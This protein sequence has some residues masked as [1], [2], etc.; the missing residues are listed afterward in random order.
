MQKCGFKW[1]CT[2]CRPKITTLNSGDET[3]CGSYKKTEAL[4]NSM[5]MEMNNIKLKMEEI[6]EKINT[7]F[8]SLKQSLDSPKSTSWADIVGEGDKE[9]KPDFVK[10]IAK[11]ITDTQKKLTISR[12]DRENN[13]IIFNV[14]ED[15]SEN[16]TTP[17][18]TTP[19]TT[20]TTTPDDNSKPLSKDIEFFNSLCSKNL[21]YDE[22]PQVELVRLGAKREKH[23]RPI[24][25][26]FQQSWD[27]RKLLSN[28]YKLKL[29][30][31]F[32]NIRIAHDMTEEDRAENKRLLDQAYQ[33]NKEEKPTEYRY[34]VRGPPWAMKT[35][36]VYPKN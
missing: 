12:E 36:K 9:K 7:N 1:F 16:P 21:G 31:K 10:K 19:T 20:I 35:I 28:L 6:Q 23:I 32:D 18:T 24:K 11:Q 2:P 22:V 34:K 3:E 8:D 33:M 4:C 29:D 27:K 15:S 26:S 13:I 14:P 17:T 25:V 30:K 5:N